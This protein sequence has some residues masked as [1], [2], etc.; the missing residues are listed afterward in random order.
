MAFRAGSNTLLIRL[1]VMTGEVRLIGEWTPDLPE[2]GSDG[3]SGGSD[4][5]PV[6]GGQ[7]GGSE[8]EDRL[9]VKIAAARG[10][11]GCR[12]GRLPPWPER[13]TS[14]WAVRGAS[15]GEVAGGPRCVRA[16]W[17]WHWRRAGASSEVVGRL[18]AGGGTRFVQRCPKSSIAGSR[19][20]VRR[21]PDGR[22]WNSRTVGASSVAGSPVWGW[23]L[24][25]C[26]R[27]RLSLAAVIIPCP[28]A[29]SKQCPS[30][31]AY[32]SR[33][34]ICEKGITLERLLFPTAIS[35]AYGALDNK[36]QT[37]WLLLLLFQNHLWIS[38]RR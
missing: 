18:V 5:W 37:Y 32:Q 21:E 16:S 34:S 35:D 36:K 3:S 29:W 10:V 25:R 22:L 14:R 8:P 24:C 23:R 11:S 17:S 38:Y 9:V 6:G 15:V 19:R 27:H 13:A 31:L 26:I 4:L 7:V 12:R 20:G 28:L 2:R 1:F 30:G 33:D